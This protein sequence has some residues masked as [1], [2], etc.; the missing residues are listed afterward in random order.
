MYLSEVAGRS[1]CSGAENHI[2]TLL[3]GLATQ[4]V[5]AELIAML[6][7]GSDYA[8]VSARLQQIARAG[9]RVVAIRRG[10]ARGTAARWLAM[11]R[12][13]ARLR[14][15]LAARRHRTVHLH[16]D[17]IVSIVVARLA[18]CRTVVLS[19]HNDEPSYAGFAWRI[20]L[21][22]V[23]RVVDRYI[24]ITTHVQRYFQRVAGVGS[25]KI[26]VVYYGIDVPAG[27]VPDR[28]RFGI[29]QDAFVVGF[30]GRLAPQKNLHAFVDAVERLPH[31]TAVL[32]GDGGLR[33]ELEQ[34][35]AVR[36]ISNIKMLG[37]I[38]NAAALMPMFD[39][40]CLPS[41]WEGL[42]LVLVEAMLQRVPIAGSRRGAIPEILG[43]GTYGVLFEPDADGIAAAIEFSR[44]HPDAM[45]LTAAAAFEYANRTFAAPRMVSEMVAVYEAL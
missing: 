45:R 8:A 6:W 31:V 23:D 24:A 2:L 15:L 36:R 42:G 35:I 30:V 28:S 38:P 3:E 18:G 39:L 20:W 19:I 11:I 33:T 26:S 4:G 25:D 5:D 29:A 9:V 21:R 13:W 27:A 22:V 1:V 43:D 41:L 16:L 7:D 14:R 10:P 12:A 44:T 32:V 17:L 37:G 34:L 40:F